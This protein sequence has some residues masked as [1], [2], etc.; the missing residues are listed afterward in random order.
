M[1]REQVSWLD[2]CSSQTMSLR[3]AV[4]H[5]AQLFG[6]HWKTVRVAERRALEQESEALPETVE[7]LT[8]VSKDITRLTLEAGHFTSLHSWGR[9]CVAWCAMFTQPSSVSF[10]TRMNRAYLVGCRPSLVTMSL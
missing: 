3:D 1:T 7:G 10:H 4:A 2:R 9:Y 5:S 8:L 6:L